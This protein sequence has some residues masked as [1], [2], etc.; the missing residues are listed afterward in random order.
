MQWASPNITIILIKT[1]R[2]LQVNKTQ[3]NL[4]ILCERIHT[5]LLPD[6]TRWNTALCWDLAGKQET[7]THNESK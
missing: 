4:N 2:N 6:E 7:I 5:Q 1:R 3:T